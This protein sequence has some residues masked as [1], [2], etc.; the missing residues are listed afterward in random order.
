MGESIM[1]S[2]LSPNYQRCPFFS[3][4]FLRKSAWWQSG[5]IALTAILAFSMCVKALAKWQ[6]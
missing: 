6:S 2:I 3:V 1:L 4:F 5:C